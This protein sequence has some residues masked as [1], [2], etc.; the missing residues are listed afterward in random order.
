MLLSVH[1]LSGLFTSE[2]ACAFSSRRQQNMSLSYG[3]THGSIENRRVFLGG[4]GLSCENLV[5]AKQTH[6]S[7]VKYVTEKDA[8]SGALSYESAIADTDGLVTDRRNLALAIF[9]ADCLSI[10]LYDPQTPAIGLIHAGWGST[11]ENI[12]SAALKLMQGQFDSRP[13]NLYAG[14]G[15]AIRNCCYEVGKDFQDTFGS[16]ENKGGRYYL[17][18]VALNRKQLL[19]SGLLQENIFDCGICTSCRNADFF[20]FRKE[21]ATCGRIMSVIMLKAI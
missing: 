4:L 20:S 15:P 5:C 1:P 17:D 11:K 13:Q 12:V 3:D 16:L 7:H 19:D 18:L 21:G 6:A 10:F 2:V 9:T 8:G 14:F